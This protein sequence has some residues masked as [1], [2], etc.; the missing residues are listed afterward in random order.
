MTINS[1]GQLTYSHV[2]D[3]SWDVNDYL[4]G[5]KSQ[6]KTWRDVYWRVWGIINFLTCSRCG[7]TFPCTELGHCKYHSEPVQFGA[8][9][10]DGSSNAAVG[11]H[12]C[13]GQKVL[14]FDP[15]QPNLVRI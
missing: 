3:K 1:K 11:T 5:L 4:I 7:E 13:C 15:T 14:R 12:G 8:V 9:L 2:K 6:L 10:A